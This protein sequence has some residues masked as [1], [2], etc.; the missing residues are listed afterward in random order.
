MEI[1]LYF[2]IGI[3]IGAFVFVLVTKKTD[4]DEGTIIFL[5]F[6][7]FLVW[8]LIIIGLIIFFLFLPVVK[9][10]AKLIEKIRKQ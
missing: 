8:P 10:L 6:M 5:T 1:L 3:I 2:I 4:E 7:S 9:Y